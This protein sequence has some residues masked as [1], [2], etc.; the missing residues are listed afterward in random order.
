[1]ALGQLDIYMQKVKL[2]PDLTHIQKLTQNGSIRLKTVKLLEDGIK[3]NLYNLGFGN[4]FV[5]MTPTT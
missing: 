1:M 4:D 2:D 5:E 3:L